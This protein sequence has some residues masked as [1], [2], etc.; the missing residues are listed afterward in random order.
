MRTIHKFT[1]TVGARFTLCVPVGAK[2]L[3]VDRDT[4]YPDDIG[5]WF[6]VDTDQREFTNRPYFVVGTGHP[7]PDEAVNHLASVK[8]GYFI[9]HIY[10]GAF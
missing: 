4:R 7:V 1:H 3:N 5:F 10:E 8:M 9:W 2:L 6:E